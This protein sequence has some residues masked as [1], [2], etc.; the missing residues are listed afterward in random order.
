MSVGEVVPKLWGVQ[1]GVYRVM[2]KDD[3]ISHSVLILLL[4]SFFGC[5]LGVVSFKT[6]PSS[7]WYDEE[8][9]S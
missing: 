2:G 6:S 9:M 1:W 8:K 7:S 3:G 4:S 5:N